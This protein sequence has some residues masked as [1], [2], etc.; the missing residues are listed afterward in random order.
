MSTEKT[1]VLVLS[2]GA[3]EGGLRQV[4]FLKAIKE[5]ELWPKV[6]R[7]VGVS[8]GAFTGALAL[9]DRIDL[10]EKTLMEIQPYHL[11]RRFNPLKAFS[12]ILFSYGWNETL[13]ELSLKKVF[14]I[15]PLQT[16]KEISQ[17]E[18]ELLVIVTPLGQNNNSNAHGKP[19]RRFERAYSS[20]EVAPEVMMQAIFASGTIP[21]MVSPHPIQEQL[22][23]DGGWIANLPLTYA[24]D[25]PDVE[26]IIAHWSVPTPSPLPKQKRSIFPQVLP[27]AHLILHLAFF[28]MRQRDE[29]EIFVAKEKTKDVRTWIELKERMNEVIDYIDSCEEISPDTKKLLQTRIRRILANAKFSFRKGKDRPIDPII[30]VAERSN[31]LSAPPLFSLKSS[32]RFFIPDDIKRELIQIGYDDTK[33]AL[34]ANGL[35]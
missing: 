4:G 26:T 15:D 31:L 11:Y 6:G 1:V 3:L 10:L 22:G 28:Q 18:S 29:R 32:K 17:A 19:L 34:Q 13:I 2:G 5:T 14:G 30:V 7:I 23:V 9:L 21:V 27:W 20:K 16:A 33:Q 24:Y 8:V 25:Y 12:R 35:I